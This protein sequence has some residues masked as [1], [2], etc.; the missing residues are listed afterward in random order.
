MG[1]NSSKAGVSSAPVSKSG[2]QSAD[3]GYTQCEDPPELDDRQ[4]E[5][6]VQKDSE[7]A[8]EPAPEQQ[9][10]KL[11]WS[12][13]ASQWRRLLRNA[14][15][16]L[17]AFLYMVSTWVRRAPPHTVL[18]Q[19]LLSLLIAPPL[20]LAYH[21]LSQNKAGGYYNGYVEMFLHLPQHF[22]AVLK[23]G[24]P[25]YK[26]EI[27]H[28][29]GDGIVRTVNGLETGVLFLL[30]SCFSI[31][32]W[33]AN[34][35]NVTSALMARCVETG[36]FF[37]LHRLIGVNVFQGQFYGLMQPE[38]MWHFDY[39]QSRGPRAEWRMTPVSQNPV[40]SY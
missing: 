26:A 5:E 1:C 19:V 4:E 30:V 18:R 2:S 20:T 12:P 13:E 38:G 37:C 36:A 15:S 6:E 23:R 34:P 31:L 22:R 24:S 8:P 28:E 29:R 3:S 25:Q 40:P 17:A 11:Q 35:G 39:V 7:P 27:E 33:P 10:K 14:Q 9:S 16:L 32:L 21:L